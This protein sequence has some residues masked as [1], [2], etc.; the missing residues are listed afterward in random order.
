MK[1]KLS[2]PQFRIN[3][4]LV[5]MSVILS[6]V[7]PLGTAVPAAASPV[8]PDF[9]DGSDGALVISS[10]TTDAP[11]D[12]AASGNAGTS[13]LSATNASF[14]PGQK[15]MIHQSQ[16]TNAGAWEVNEIA[17]YTAGTIT[18][19]NPLGNTYTTGA[20][21]LVLKEYTDV[22]VNSGVTW[23]AKAWNGTVG[24]VLAFLANGTV[25]VNGTITASEKGFRGGTTVANSS[26]N[27]GEGINGMGTISTAANGNGGGGG[28]A[29]DAADA[30]G[31]GGGNGTAGEDGHP[32]S[33]AS[34]PENA[35]GGTGGSVN[36][37]AD[38]SVLIFG[39]GGGSGG[40]HTVGNENVD[41]GKGGGIITIFAEIITVSGSITSNGGTN[42]TLVT[43]S[44]GG[45]GG[46]GGSILITSQ[47]AS[48][49][50][51]LITAIGAAG[52][53]TIGGGDGG[54]G[55]NGRIRIEYCDALSGSTN[56]G[57]SVENIMCQPPNQPPT[58]DAGGPYTGFEGSAIPMSEA[59]ATDPDV[60]SLTYSWSVDS[61]LCSFDDPSA[62][63][64]D[65]TCIDNGDYTATLTV[66]DGI[67]PPE[68]SWARVT[69]NNVAPAIITLTLSPATIDENQSVTL[70]GSF[71]DPGILD[72]HEVVIDWGDGSNDRIE[73]DANVLNFGPVS[74][75][76]LDDGPYPGNGT[77]TDMN[78][79]QVIVTDKDNDSDNEDETVAVS[80]VAPIITSVSGPIAPI[81]LDSPAATVNIIVN[82]TDVGSKDAHTCT[83]VWDDGSPNT[84]V[85]A[86]GTGN[87]SCTASHSY[88]TSGVNT[89]G[90][91]VN[92]DDTGSAT[93]N[94]EFVIIYDPQGGFV[95]GGGWIDS[96][97]G[98][99]KPDETLSGKAT[100][101][102]VSKYK[103]GATV[104]TGNTEFQFHA[105][106]FNFHSQSYEWLVVNQNSSNA[107]FKGV[108]TING[109]GSY[110][111]MLWAGDGNPDTFRIKIWWEDSAGEH[112]IYDN[113]G[114]QAIGGGNIVVHTSK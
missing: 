32:G 101:G 3:I 33:R 100:F 84:V 98:A 36:V 18:T 90:V 14:A 102:F 25:A 59:S 10:H 54:A 69:V 88:T 85:N 66:S 95:T 5:L 110:K 49:G 28:E 41:G 24:G 55:G 107:Q 65:L 43:G 48:L 52:Q 9:G 99:Y 73:L 76:Y 78:D 93:S 40:E 15:I 114:N 26:G 31:G 29:G 13:S 19:T 51:L 71:T 57:A 92:D 112:V 96:P 6:L 50:S 113:G 103:K 20:Q 74:H 60:D 42:V 35:V 86:P 77:P 34:Q 27:Q 64:P 104:P 94:W 23:T 89:V 2:I 11:I 44:G 72:T 30:G 63:N 22:T 21:V 7:G 68:S 83:F 105:A 91:T 81:A 67:N 82:F 56:P 17:S 1:Q 79:V 109:D 46:A 61:T 8:N 12:S 108:G 106:G 38:L 47:T 80:N 45:G 111:F 16:G 53:T 75:T 97:A 58:P 4:V 62:L 87:G 37:A 39:G 70:S